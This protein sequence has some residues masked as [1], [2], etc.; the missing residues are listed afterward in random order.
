MKLEINELSNEQEI[1]KCQEENDV[2]ADNSDCDVPQ[3][4]ATRRKVE[5]MLNERKD[6]KLTTKFSQ[7][8]QALHLLR[9]D[10]QKQVLQ[11]FE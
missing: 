11:K 9:E 1:S 2:D 8:A 5:E 4:R 10:L 7:E 3:P 6:K